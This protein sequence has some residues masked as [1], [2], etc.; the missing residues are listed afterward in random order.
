MKN[1]N[2]EIKE[3]KSKKNHYCSY[4]CYWK[5]K[6]E[7]IPKG[8][9]NPCYSRIN[10]TCTNCGKDIKVTPYQNNIK[11]SYGDNHNFCSQNCYWEYRSKY[12]VSNKSVSANTIFTPERLE[13]MRLIFLKNCRSSKKV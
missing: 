10:T 8:E 11:N 1:F 4:S 12:Y 3:Y 9:N 5:H 6:P 2:N 7:I 13:K